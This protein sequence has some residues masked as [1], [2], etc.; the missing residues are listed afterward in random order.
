MHAL[1]ARV[2]AAIRQRGLIS[3]G[4]G[5]LVAVS[6]GLDSMVLLHALHAL[7]PARGWRLVVAHFNHRLRAAHSS[8]DASFVIRSARSLGLECVMEAGD[9]RSE[10][11]ARGW[12]VEMAARKLRHEFLAR[13]ARRF[14]LST[15]ALAHHADDQ[16]ELF[17]LRLFRGAGSGLAGMKWRSPSS[18]DSFVTLVRPLL[19]QP[20]AALV[21]FAQEAKILF[22]TDESNASVDI[23]RNRVR[24]EL[25]PLLRKH[26]QPGVERSILRTMDILASESELAVELARK[27]LDRRRGPF[28]ELPVAVQRQCL[29]LQ[30]AGVGI[31]AEFEL[32]EQ[33]RSQP[34]VRH[35]WR[36]AWLVWDAVRG[37]MVQENAAPESV[38]DT[39]VK[40]EL[41][42]VLG[43][44]V[45]DGVEMKW[46]FRSSSRVD[47]LRRS[48][49]KESFDADQIGPFVCLRHWRAG[50][51]FRPSGMAHPVKLQDL[52][53]N[54]KVPAA[55]RH[56]RLLAESADGRIFW[57]EGLRIGQEFKLT[58]R[59][60]RQLIWSWKRT[61]V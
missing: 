31:A 18:A 3:P 6:G 55:E 48:E 7:A 40:I 29:C 44:A 52:F 19:D 56:G 27:W 47:G 60:R 15:A 41:G 53:M 12:S 5:V 37:A 21:E 1:L 59:T 30:L 11:A 24:H 43:K 14:N 34:G 54:A 38:A 33:L 23:A 28:M 9:V 8:R 39:Q 61:A 2:E 49:F 22:R 32:I 51:R 58:P 36:D 17:F 20:K 57:V 25:L 4:Q 45:F 13:T 10:A 35:S 46:R 26:Y 42:A 50:D 16:V